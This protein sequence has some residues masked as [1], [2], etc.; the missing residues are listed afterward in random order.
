VRECRDP[1]IAEFLSANFNNIRKETT[2]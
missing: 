2:L 1:V